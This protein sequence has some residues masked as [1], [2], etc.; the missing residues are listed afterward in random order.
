MTLVV[1]DE[2]RARDYELPTLRAVISSG[3]RSP[4]GIWKDIFELMHPAEV[5]TGYG[6]TE[7]TA[8][9]T[10]TRPDDPFERLLTTNGR[11]RDVGP[12]RRS[13]ARRQARRLQGR[14]IPT[15][16]GRLRPARSAN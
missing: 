1:L 10:L 14:S 7:V 15:A 4:A 8:T 12:C 13:R 3:Q 6:M 5:T 16:G 9:T 2:L 11:M